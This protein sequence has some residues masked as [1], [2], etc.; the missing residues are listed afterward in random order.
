[1]LPPVDHGL[2]FRQGREHLLIQAPV[3]ELAV[4]GLE[5]AV[6][7]EFDAIYVV[8]GDAVPVDPIQHRPRCHLRAVLAGDPR[9][10]ASPG[11]QRVQLVYNAPSSDSRLHH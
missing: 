2:G 6:L 3:P 10:L 7:L 1:M 4:E 9:K 8:A 5:E 11:D